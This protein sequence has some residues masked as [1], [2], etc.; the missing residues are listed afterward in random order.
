MI[1]KVMNVQVQ[2]TYLLSLS[3]SERTCQGFGKL[4]SDYKKPSC[5]KFEKN[6]NWNDY[7]IPNIFKKT[8]TKGFSEF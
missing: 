7:L 6:K 8:C 1:L 3:N 4:F 2:F 5:L